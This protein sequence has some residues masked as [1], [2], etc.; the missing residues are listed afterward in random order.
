[1]SFPTL[2][3]GTASVDYYAAVG[4]PAGGITYTDDPSLRTVINAILACDTAQQPA[5]LIV[6]DFDAIAPYTGSGATATIGGNPMSLIIDH[7]G[8]DGDGHYSLT[9]MALL[10][11]D[12]TTIFTDATFVLSTPG[13]SAAG[14]PYI[15]G[16]VDIIKLFYNV[17][18]ILNYGFGVGY[19][20]CGNDSVD[21]TVTPPL[22]ALT[23]DLAVATWGNNSSAGNAGNVISDPADFSRMLISGTCNGSIN[24]RQIPSDGSYSARAARDPAGPHFW[25]NGA[26]VL[27]ALL[28][29]SPPSAVFVPNTIGDTLTVGEAAIVGVGLVVGAITTGASFTVAAGLILS[30]NPPPATETFTGRSVAIVVCSGP[31]PLWTLTPD[32]ATPVRERLGFLTDVL[33]AWTGTEQRRILRIAPRRVFNFATLAQGQEKRYI[34]NALFGWSALVWYIPIFPDGQRLLGS[35]SIG[36]STVECDTVNR[37]FVAG[38]L[39]ILIHDALTA[40]V[41]LVNTIASG[42][43]H[44]SAP[45]SSAWPVGSRLYPLRSARLLTYPKVTAESQEICS[46]SIEFT[47]NEPSD[48]PAASGLPVYRTLPVLEDSPDVTSAPGGDYTRLANITDSVT[49]AIDVD[50]TALMGFPGN[51]HQWFLK[52]RSARAAFRSLLYLLKG[53]A[54]MIWVPSYNADLLLIGSLGSSA[55]AMTVEACGLV[56]LAAVQNRRDIRIELIT[57][58]VYYRRMVSAA[59]GSPGQEVVTLD[60]ALGAA[61]TA[62]QVR[63]I[64]FMALSRLDADEIEITHLTMSDGLATAQARF[65][66]VNFEP[67]V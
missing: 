14:T 62:A 57:G 9:A 24:Y 4:S 46:L 28:R 67:S 21:V 8:A 32:W 48:W 34:E 64:S 63:R 19:V 60:S 59:A 55:V 20:A 41:L 6:V 25:W 2:V 45:A 3:P 39:A 22:D 66:A 53:R 49:G 65:A 29:G 27:L 37:D 33:P 58:T 11:F 13:T 18:P 17:D 36:D 5:I 51:V 42:A 54:M 31:P 10:C 61:I 56:Q 7:R 44:L 15:A 52:G 1:M 50:D 35:V 23:G 38:G 40:E 16:A 30:T 26:S 12:A 43:L 47:L